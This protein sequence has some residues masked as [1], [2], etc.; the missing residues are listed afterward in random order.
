MLKFAV[1]YLCVAVVTDPI[2]DHA[3]SLDRG[4][5]FEPLR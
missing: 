5:D 2:D 1:G 3:R 4:F